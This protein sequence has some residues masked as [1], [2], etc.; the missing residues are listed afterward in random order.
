MNVKHL[1]ISIFNVFGIIFQVC[2]FTFY[3][4]PSGKLAETLSQLTEKWFSGQ[5]IPMIMASTLIEAEEDN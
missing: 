1:F 2:F 3:E 4:D 5:E